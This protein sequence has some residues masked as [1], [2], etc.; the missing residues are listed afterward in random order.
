MVT[1]KD[2]NVVT[3]KSV[4]ELEQLDRDEYRFTAQNVYRQW[5]EQF[6]DE[7]TGLITPIT[8]NELLFA[9]GVELNTD[10]FSTILF[11]LQTGDMEE[12]HMSN[13]QRRA[14]LI[15]NRGFGLWVVKAIGNKFKPK[16][17]LRASNAMAAYECAKDFIELNYTGDFFIKSIKT[18][19]DCIIIEPKEEEEARDV[20]KSWYSVSILLD[21]EHAPDD[22]ETQGPYDFVVY[23]ETVEAAKAVIEN[24]IANKRS[25]DGVEDKYSIKMVQATTIGANVI[26]PREFCM[27]Y[28]KGGEE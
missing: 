13:V 24:Y 14:T 17:M 22:V 3:I 18:Y 25:E 23:A 1:K 2:E 21:I 15:G 9:K 27:A 6:V 12:L 20:F 16:M 4:A 19:D 7:D 26:V 10:D 11:H 28:Q 5:K 8:R